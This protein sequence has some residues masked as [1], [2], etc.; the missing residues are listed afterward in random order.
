M[1]AR[2]ASGKKLGRITGKRGSL[3]Q[4]CVEQ[5]EKIDFLLKN[6][7]PKRQIAELLGISSGTL[8]RYL[9]YTD[10]FVPQKRHSEKWENGIYQ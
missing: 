6:G 9:V 1:S 8:Y 7:T 3:N 5:S 10:R 4:K 2:K